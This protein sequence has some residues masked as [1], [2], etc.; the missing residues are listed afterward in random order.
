MAS[1]LTLGETLQQRGIS[2]RSFLKFCVV[3]ASILYSYPEFMLRV[4]PFNSGEHYVIVS[5]WLLADFGG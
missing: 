4:F 3:T 5:V 2:R 1:N